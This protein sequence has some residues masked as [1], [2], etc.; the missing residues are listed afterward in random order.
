M[1]YLF[2]CMEEDPFP[3]INVSKKDIHAY[4]RNQNSCVLKYS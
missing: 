3:G 4:S 2:I 1:Y